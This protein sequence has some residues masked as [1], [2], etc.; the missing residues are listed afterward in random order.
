MKVWL[1]VILVGLAV[2]RYPQFATGLLVHQFPHFPNEVGEISCTMNLPA[3]VA[4]RELPRILPVLFL[5]RLNDWLLVK[6]ERRRAIKVELDAISTIVEGV[7]EKAQP[8]ATD[9]RKGNTP[10]GQGHA[11]AVA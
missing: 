3:G 9:F 8:V 2:N 11:I 5:K 1:L 10:V 4:F 6:D 7:S